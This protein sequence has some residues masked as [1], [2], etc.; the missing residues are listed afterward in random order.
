MQKIFSSILMLGICSL[1]GVPAVIY[2]QASTFTPTPYVVLAPLPGTTIDKDTCPSTGCTSDINHYL[3]G[4][5]YLVIGV[6]AMLSFIYF[7]IW[8]FQYAVSDSAGVKS[9]MKKKLQDTGIGFLLI[10]CSYGLINT[11]SPRLLD[12][13]L[14]ISTPST[15]QQTGG[16]FGGDGGGGG[17]NA[18][19][20]INGYDIGPYAT[21]ANHEAVVASIYNGLAKVSIDTGGIIDKYIQSNSPGS[22]V[23]GN[24]ILKAAQNYDVDPKLL[25]ALM[26]TDSHY[27]TDGLGKT[28]CNPGNVGNNGKTTNNLCGSSDPW[29]TGVDAVARWLAAHRA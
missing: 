19:Y 26:E 17:N 28:T 9:D 15:A 22:P 10:I 29:Q 23:T 21:A 18:P 11:I 25:M 27:G 2:A 24:M 8:G 7:T 4:F 6:G 1:I 14:D 12:L 16:V 3:G 20:I 5:L 13:K